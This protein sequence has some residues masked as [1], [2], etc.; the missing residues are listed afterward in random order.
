M[1]RGV[2]NN[3]NLLIRI[4]LSSGLDFQLC[5]PP[6]DWSSSTA[7]W[8]P[9][10]ECRSPFGWTVA[11]K[12]IF[13]RL[14]Y[15]R[16]RAGVKVSLVL[17]SSQGLPFPSRRAISPPSETPFCFYILPGLRLILRP[18]QIGLREEFLFFSGTPS[19]IIR[20]P[21]KVLRHGVL[22][23]TN[24]ARASLCLMSLRHC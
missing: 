19:S 15:E 8:F 12:T 14:P 7:L 10:I 23:F 21:E 22:F 1:N 13:D 5:I 9:E 4:H 17:K 18:P 11:W 2:P 20:L 6:L 3:L 24:P 16:A